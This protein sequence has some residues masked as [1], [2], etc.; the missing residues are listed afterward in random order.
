MKQEQWMSLS[1]A[2][3]ILSEDLEGAPDRLVQATWGF[4]Q[5]GIQQKLG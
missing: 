2:S 4:L 1:M 5:L 3:Y